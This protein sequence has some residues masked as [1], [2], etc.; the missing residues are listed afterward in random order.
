VIKLNPIAVAFGT[1][2][3]TL[4]LLA[5]GLG[6]SGAYAAGSKQPAN[7]R[8]PLPKFSRPLPLTE[9]QASW[10]K[11]KNIV[12]KWSESAYQIIKTWR[13]PCQAVR[14]E[15]LYEGDPDGPGHLPPG[16]YEGLHSPPNPFVDPKT[17]EVLACEAVIVFLPP[18]APIERVEEVLEHEF[19]HT[20]FYRLWTMSPEFSAAFAEDDSEIWVRVLMHDDE[21]LRQQGLIE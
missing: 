18:D 10:L 7:R 9:Q 4:S 1:A 8:C 19:L 14:V 6:I 17:G 20:I 16:I 3:L 21:W 15:T 5:I 11:A 2:A 13:R 12:R